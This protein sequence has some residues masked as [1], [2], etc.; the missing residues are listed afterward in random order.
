MP[1]HRMV[2]AQAA[3]VMPFRAAVLGIDDDE[4]QRTRLRTLRMAAY[5]HL[6]GEARIIREPG[7]GTPVHLAPRVR[8]G[9]TRSRMRW[10][11]APALARPS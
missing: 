5:D 1:D 7:Q 4:E 9:G 3:G 2:A 10:P 6:D 11:R 8:P